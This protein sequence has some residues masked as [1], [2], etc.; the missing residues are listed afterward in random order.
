MTK[1]D[2]S[3]DDKHNNLFT[4]FDQMIYFGGDNSFMIHYTSNIVTNDYKRVTRKHPLSHEQTIFSNQVSLNLSN[5]QYIN[6][7]S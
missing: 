2:K 5:S 7:T 4:Y 6:H 1:K 3:K